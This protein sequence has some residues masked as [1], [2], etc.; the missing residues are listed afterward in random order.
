[1]LR[2]SMASS[3]PC[4]RWATPLTP[5]S[6]P[7]A[8]QSMRALL[9]SAANAWSSAYCDLDF[10][11]SAAQWI[12]RALETLAPPA[13]LRSRVIEVDF[14]AKPPS[15]EIVEAEIVEH[16]NLNS[17]R[18]EKET[19][20]LALAFDGV[21]PAY[22]PGDYLDLYAENDPAEVDEL[23][24]AAALPEDDTLRAGLIKSRDITTLSLKNLDTYAALT[25]PGDVKALLAAGE[26]RALIVRPPLI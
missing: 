2:A 15:P 25:G 8:R 13:A 11:G 17:S 3:S 14:A 10:A 18:S 6:A 12:D 16:I 24:T 7:W 19:I 20:H 26:G 23:L 9:R 21:A 1:M 22:Q 4:W 5:S